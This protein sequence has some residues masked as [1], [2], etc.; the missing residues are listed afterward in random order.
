[1]YPTFSLVLYFLFCLFLFLLYIICHF[2]GFLFSII[3][4][5]FSNSSLTT[6]PPSC[7]Y[8]PLFLFINLPTFVINHFSLLLL[9]H[10]LSLP[11]LFLTSSSIACLFN[12]SLFLPSIIHHSPPLTFPLSVPVPP[13]PDVSL[14]SSSL[15]YLLFSFILRP[16][17]SLL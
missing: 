4:S 15:S 8:F 14:K 1:M 3:V 7:F 17:F 16:Y 5:S 6:S 2:S 12:S 13:L 11:N 9:Y 10:Y